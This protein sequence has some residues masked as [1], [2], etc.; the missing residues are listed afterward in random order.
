MREGYDVTLDNHPHF[1]I[2][3]RSVLAGSLAVPALLGS[4][5]ASA[6]TAAALTMFTFIGAGQ[7]VVPKEVRAEYMRAN[8][9][10]RVDLLEGSNAE[11]LPK[12]IA[13]RQIDPNSPLV[14][15][16]YFNAEAA[17]RGEQV[18]LWSGLDPALVPNLADIVSA[19]RRPK[20]L[21]V[22]WGLT[23]VVLA[24]NTEKVKTPPKSW[25]A[26]WDPAYKGRVLLRAAPNFFLNG[27]VTAARENGGDEKA[28]GKGFE[29]ISKAAAA[30]QIHSFFNSTD[31][32]KTL[33]TRGDV[34]IAPAFASMILNFK[35]EGAPVDYV[36]PDEGM[37]AVPQNLML[38][39]GGTPEQQ[40]HAQTMINWLLDPERLARYCTLTKSAPA[41]RKVKLPDQLAREPAYQIASIEKAIQFDWKT[42]A[43]ET[44]RWIERWNREVVARTK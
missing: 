36:I 12:M 3:R 24:Y 18:G 23:P 27:L 7:D 9:G 31:Q 32:I 42:I 17:A 30:G 44:P 28:I 5:A 11:T 39:A 37:I 6:Q 22:G 10:V 35:A 16:G 1:S 33:L 29:V 15:F 34:H 25:S 43:Q 40:R 2:T 20:D 41:N 19:Y 38:A 21:G 4:R 26:L 14:H 8:P 13:A